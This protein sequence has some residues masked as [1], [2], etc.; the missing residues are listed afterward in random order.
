MA[1][2][3]KIKEQVSVPERAVHGARLS[4][5]SSVLRANGYVG[6][7]EASRLLCN[8]ISTVY[9]WLDSSLV[10]SVQVGHRKY[11]KLASLIKHVGPDVAEIFGLTEFQQHICNQTN[12]ILE[13]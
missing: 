9:K 1:R 12:S 6:V 2:R 10:E 7:A 4:R 11:I 8:D 3:Q 13:E 5:Q